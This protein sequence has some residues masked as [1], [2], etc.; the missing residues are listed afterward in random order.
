[1]ETNHAFLIYFILYIYIS[2]FTYFVYMNWSVKQLC[3]FGLFMF[4]LNSCLNQTRIWTKKTVPAPLC[5]CACTSYVTDGF[6]V[7]CVRVPCV[8]CCATP[9]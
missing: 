2:Y 8:P 4:I 9:S 5:V 7:P 6:T 1:M 3:I